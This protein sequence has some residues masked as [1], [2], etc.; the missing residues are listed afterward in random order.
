MTCCE[1]E[2]GCWPHVIIDKGKACFE[3]YPKS[4]TPYRYL[5]SGT[6]IGKASTAKDMLAAV[7]EEAGK[8]FANANDQKLV[9]DMF[10]QGRFGIQLDYHARLFQSMHMTYDKPLAFCDPIKDIEVIGDGR[11]HNK[12]TDSLPSVFHFNGGGKRHHLNM[13]AQLWYKKQAK[14]NTKDAM[15]TI[16]DTEISVPIPTNRDRKLKFKDICREYFK[17]KL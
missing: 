15:R 3:G 10:M 9:A 16:A 12:R 17:G 2:C 11:F 4:P 13:E 7:M 1:G 6:W 5:N 8:D 14:Y